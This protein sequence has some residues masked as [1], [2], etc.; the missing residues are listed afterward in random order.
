M[1]ANLL[2][3]FITNIAGLL[4]DSLAVELCVDDVPLPKLYREVYLPLA[5]INIHWQS[6]IHTI[7]HR[8]YSVDT[9]KSVCSTPYISYLDSQLDGSL[10]FLVRSL[11]LQVDC[12]EVVDGQT[13]KWLT[14]H[15]LRV[16]GNV[17]KLE[18]TLTASDLVDMPSS[19]NEGSKGIYEFISAIKQIVPN[20]RNVVVRDFMQYP[21]IDKDFSQALGQFIR[22]M[23]SGTLSN[24]LVYSTSVDDMAKYSVTDGKLA[25]IEYR[26]RS[27]SEKYMRV[28]Y[29]NAE[30][31]E[32]LRIVYERTSQAIDLTKDRAG[33]EYQYP[34]LRKLEFT[35]NTT[36]MVPTKLNGTAGE[37]VAFPSLRHIHLDIEYPYKDNTLFRGN[38]DKFEYLHIL[39]TSYALQALGET[40]GQFKQ[41]VDVSLNRVLGYKWGASA[42]GG[43]GNELVRRML[44]ESRKVRKFGAPCMSDVQDLLLTNPINVPSIQRLDLCNT[45]LGLLDT[46]ELLQRFP[47][48]VY[49]RCSF[50]GSWTLGDIMSSQ[51]EVAEEL[52]KPQYQKLGRRL[53][54]LDLWKG[55]NVD[56]DHQDN[57][58]RVALTT[59]FI[60]LLVVVCQ[61]PFTLLVPPKYSY[62]YLTELVK[63][64]KAPPYDKFAHIIE[65]LNPKIKEII[66][67]RMTC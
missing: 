64:I 8:E 47:E 33:R 27:S 61:H 18:I 23:F 52:R 39:P 34:R 40:D 31:L 32:S 51:S 26:W 60:L 13:A 63:Y 44:R 14:C 28:I 25:H 4:K 58:E 43:R 16:Y 67:F 41:L 57:N 12:Q 20:V 50:N 66:E 30:S 29:N 19:T 65:K 36:Q 21:T 62:S 45:Y 59:I 53:K 42:F 54:Y 17:D 35:S 55:T 6:V 15:P 3:T 38:L 49:L 56:E 24:T 22:Q 11:S 2:P 9:K 5:D 37:V 1:F 46:L 10:C 48:L 7:T